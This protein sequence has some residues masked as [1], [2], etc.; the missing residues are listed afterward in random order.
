MKKT[1]LFC[2]IVSIILSLFGCSA[3]NRSN[4]NET[5]TNEYSDQNTSKD[6]TTVE[7][8]T[9]SEV[10]E[11]ETIDEEPNSDLTDDV[12]NTIVYGKTLQ[13]ESIKIFEEDDDS[14][15]HTHEYNDP[16]A[17][18]EIKVTINGIEYDG[19]Y[20]GSAVLPRSDMNVDLYML[21]GVTVR[22]GLLRSKVLVNKE[23][24]E[25]VEYV[26]I[27][28]KA[29]LDSEAD[30]KAFVEEMVGKQV[31]LKGFDYKCT[32]HYYAML[33]GGV[34]SSVVPGFRVC[35][36][37]EQLGC[38]SFYYTKSIQNYKLLDHVSA[39]FNFDRSTG[40]YF[41]S[42]EIYEQ[43]HG[44]VFSELLSHSDKFEAHLLSYLPTRIHE[45]REMK[46]LEIDST[47][48]FVKNGTPYILINSTVTFISKNDPSY[49][50]TARV[51]T[52]SCLQ[53]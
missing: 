8:T 3:M 51:S 16:T 21:S 5:T 41:Y 27:P 13:L 45:N 32:T 14:D 31:E 4:Q 19:V 29:E 17:K 48:L 44:D 9:S 49:E 50:L 25:I 46:K 42:L 28:L 39:E 10:L 12:F 40:E 23:N 33:E 26:N 24:G 22:D 7:E 36:E 18:K 15:F 20:N 38:Y 37:S 11:V 47:E 53:E 35:G 30:F 6:E 52:V 2:L 34:D 43:D 1:I